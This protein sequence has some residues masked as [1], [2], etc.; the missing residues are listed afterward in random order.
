MKTINSRSP[1]FIQIEGSTNTTLKLFIWNGNIEPITETYS[2]TKAAPS[3]EQTTGNYEISN[4]LQEY[5]DNIN[6][7][8]STTPASEEIKSF[9]NFKAVL[10]SNGVNKTL[11]FKARVAADSG[12]FEAENCLGTFMQDYFIG[13]ATDGYSNY[14]GGYNQ[15]NLL[16]VVA[17]T[18][19]AKTIN[20][21]QGSNNAYVN[22]L[23]EHDGSTV[24]SEYVH[25]GATTVVNIL[26]S[27]ISKGV[28]NMKVPFRLSSFT[29]SNILRIKKG[30]FVLYSYNVVPICET[31]YT[32]VVCQFINRYGGWQFLT[33][34]KAQ[35]NTINV[36]K[37]NYNL[38][39]DSIN[40][41]PK[42]G[43]TKSFN[44]NGTQKVSLNTGFVNENYSDLIQD[45]LLSNTVLLDSKPVIV[46]SSGSDLKT[47]VKDKNI[48]YQID[49]EYS[50]SLINNVI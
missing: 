25:N 11:A 30:G 12:I 49:F 16:P 3:T 19:S 5:I 43:Q 37:T 23:I 9:A 33:F 32:P 46:A 34:F 17:L 14:L 39:P 35:T 29:L 4:Y 20:Y 44:I 47:S 8:F 10:Y 7:T 38:L 28:Y 1:F 24:T 6:P 26:D 42:R 27:T 40:Y 2:F 31:K 50:F 45:L 13:V 18:D 41:N 48:N 15:T 22:V 21:L 36:E